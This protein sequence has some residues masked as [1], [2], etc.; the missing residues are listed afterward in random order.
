MSHFLVQPVNKPFSG[1][2]DRLNSNLLVAKLDIAS[3]G[4]KIANPMEPPKRNYFGV[5]LIKT[6]CTQGITKVY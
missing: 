6:L 5:Y 1:D 4:H 2:F 3:Q